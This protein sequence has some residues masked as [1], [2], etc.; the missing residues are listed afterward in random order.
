MIG[1]TPLGFK[2]HFDLTEK[3]AYRIQIPLDHLMSRVPYLDLIKL[4]L[5]MLTKV[6]ST[7][8][9]SRTKIGDQTLMSDAHSH[10]L[11]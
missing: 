8:K 7:T 11:Q 2:F 3:E 10:K 5:K 6:S 9:P 1:Q 4:S